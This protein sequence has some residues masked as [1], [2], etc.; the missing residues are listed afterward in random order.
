MQVTMH[1]DSDDDEQN[2]NSMLV[3]N[4]KH[5]LVSCDTSMLTMHKQSNLFARWLN[6]IYARYAMGMDQKNLLL[7]LL[8]IRGNSTSNAHK[9][10]THAFCY[11]KLLE[12]T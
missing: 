1:S 9:K 6:G 4:E 7:G 3:R 2:S 5:H 12:P 11:R 10:A 8:L